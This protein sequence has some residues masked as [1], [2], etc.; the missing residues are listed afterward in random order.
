MSRPIVIAVL[1]VSA[2]FT[3]CENRGSAQTAGAK[4]DQALG[5]VKN[6][7][8]ATGDKLEDAAHDADKDIKKA[9]RDVKDGAQKAADE[10]NK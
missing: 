9:A 8:E 7:A 10:L 2:L 1:C 3:A 5:K 4:V 6:A